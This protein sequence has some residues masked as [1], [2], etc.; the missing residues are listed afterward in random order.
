[1]TTGT[2]T[3]PAAP[4]APAATVLLL[5]ESESG[6]L[7]VLMTKRAAGLAFMAGLW[8]FPGG[9]MEVVDQS[10]PST[11]LALPAV[12]GKRGWYVSDVTGQLSATDNP[13]GCG[14]G[15]R[16]RIQGPGP[17][18]NVSSRLVPRLTSDNL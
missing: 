6:R 4:V 7:E 17:A 15:V 3:A 13:A 10:A 5:R 14:A 2:T 9:R 18:R 11:G 8:V 1:M 16:R 12:N